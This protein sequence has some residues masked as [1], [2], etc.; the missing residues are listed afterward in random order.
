MDL[1]ISLPDGLA[2]ALRREADRRGVEPRQCAAQII[3]QHLPTAGRSDGLRKLFARWAAEDQ[4][5]DPA[6]LEQRNAEWE[7]LK[8]ALNANRT[9]GRKLFPENGE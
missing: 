3:E 5:N 8:R 9:S 6:E 2:T 7:Q 4:T 1:T